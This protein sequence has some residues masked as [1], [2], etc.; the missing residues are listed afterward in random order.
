MSAQQLEIFYNTTHIRGDELQK[1]RLIASGQCRSIFDFFK[2]NPEG[3]FTP[4]EVQMYS[5]LGQAPITS[6]RR[7]LNTLTEQGLLIKTSL[8][9]DGDYGMKNHTWKLA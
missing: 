9:K 2:G 6:I 1:R 8:M 3:Y 7:A 4:F 5:N